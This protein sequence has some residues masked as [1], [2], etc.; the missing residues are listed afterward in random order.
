MVANSGYESKSSEELKKILLETN[1]ASMS[2]KEQNSQSQIV[3]F[4]S[5][6]KTKDLINK[7]EK[8]KLNHQLEILGKKIKSQRDGPEPS[9]QS[10]IKILEP[11]GK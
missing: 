5:D 10:L 4:S 1:I 11:D 2:S 7:V 3:S 8:S 9:V 6:P